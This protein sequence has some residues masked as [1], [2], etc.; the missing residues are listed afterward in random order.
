MSDLGYVIE[1]DLAAATA[2]PRSLEEGRLREVMLGRGHNSLRLLA[3]TETCPDPLSPQNPLLMTCGLLTGTPTPTAARVQIS[4]R[5][6]L[7]GLLGSSSVGGKVGPALHSIGV[8]SLEVLGASES[9]V[10]LMLDGD[11]VEFCEASHLWGL[12]SPETAARLFEDLDDDGLVMLIIGPAGEKRVP[13]AC[14]VTQKGHAAGRTGMGAVMGAKMVKAIVIRPRR[15]KPEVDERV[16]EAVQAYVGSIRSSPDYQAASAWGTTYGVLPANEL[17]MLAT[18]NYQSGQFAGADAIDGPSMDRFVKRHRSCQGCPVRCKAELELQSG[19]YAGLMVERPDFEPIVSWGA[20]AALGDAEA[21]AYI[22]NL[23]DRLGLDSVSAGN[24]VGFAMALYENGIITKE[25]TGGLDIPWGSVEAAETLVQQM[26]A[27]EGFGGLLGKGVREAARLIGRGAE[28]HAIHVKGLEL[29]AYDPR[30]AFA[31]GLGY[32]V[33]SRG[34]DF[35][36]VYA[37]HDYVLTPNEAA[38]RYGRREAADRF[39]TVGKAEMVRRSMA[40]CA[41]LDAIGICKFPALSLINAY[42]LVLEAR[43]VSVVAGL[44]TTP[45]ELFELGERI[46]NIERLF[47]LRCGLDPADDALPAVFLEDPLT[48]GPSAGHTIELEPML[49]EF[50]ALMGWDQAGRPTP[51]RLRELGLERFAGELR[52]PTIEEV[53]SSC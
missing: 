6:P 7:T 8:Q 48:E 35:T 39:S 11:S 22:H 23:C 4:A 36:S 38:V 43:L 51:A 50:Y 25:D 28:R 9:P 33:S 12:E 53:T 46:L 3:L 37:R 32:A 20:K 17:G 13:I 31:S 49:R 40:I 24:A 26:A 44:E 42:D 16:R 27:A 5:S 41:V 29:T 47:N 30:G 10:Y 52:Q 15:R 34:G 21:T 14:I 45:A 1:V 19:S 18:R 2:R